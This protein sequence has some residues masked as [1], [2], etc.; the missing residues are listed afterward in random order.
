MFSR[1]VPQGQDLGQD[2][3]VASVGLRRFQQNVARPIADRFARPAKASN[4]AYSSSV[5]FVLM[6]F[7]RRE[8]ME[9]TP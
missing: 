8:G 5:T 4:W 7:V 9:F 2:D 6:D 1:I 3:L